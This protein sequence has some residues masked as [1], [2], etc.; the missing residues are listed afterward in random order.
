MTQAA[1]AFRSNIHYSYIG[2]LETGQRNPSVDMLAR[3]AKAL[4]MDLGD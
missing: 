3:L 4:E 1:L 2:S